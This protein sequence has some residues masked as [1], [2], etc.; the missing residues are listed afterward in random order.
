MD[1]ESTILIVDDDPINLQILASYLKDDYAIKIATS[2][3]QC[4]EICALEAKPDLILLDVDMPE[5]DG[6]AVCKHLK[7]NGNT[8]EIPVI[9]VTALTSEED[10]EKALLLGAVDFLSKPV[11]AGILKAR[12]STHLELKLRR[13]QFE[14]MAMKDQLTGLFNRHY[15][16][17][18][19]NHQVARAMRK[20]CS[21]S[22]MMVDI[23]HFKNI[24]DTH[25]HSVG[26]AVLIAVATLLKQESRQEDIVARFG[27]EEF[28]IFLDDCGTAV[29]QKIAERIR[30][31]IE[32]SKPSDLLITASIGIAELHNGKEGF[33]NL[34]KRADDAM[35]LAKEKGRNRV[36]VDRAFRNNKPS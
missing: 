32:E 34:V 30:N 19:A 17:E 22:L 5:L 16:I 7:Q 11:R 36:I 24:N 9:F 31:R 1:R 15:L 4:I 28:V 13:D 21:I 14:E 20:D 3:E 2:G 35:Y 33:A 23:D 25:G 6:Y 26:D 18:S 12:L 27:G 8:A 10:E 29:A